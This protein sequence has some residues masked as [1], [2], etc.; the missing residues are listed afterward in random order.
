VQRQYHD[1]QRNIASRSDSPAWSRRRPAVHG[2]FGVA[3]STD[4]RILHDHT[5]GKPNIW[6]ERL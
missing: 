3:V 4:D 6:C 1:Q 5:Q 2:G